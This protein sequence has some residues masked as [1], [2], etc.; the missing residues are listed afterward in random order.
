MAKRGRARSRA[1]NRAG[2]GGNQLLTRS[3]LDRR[4]WAVP[5]TNSLLFA[6]GTGASPMG[7]IAPTV[8]LVKWAL[9]RLATATWLW[10]FSIS[11]FDGSV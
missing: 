7:W 5:I 1:S 6:A 11:W 4:A 8:V 9:P 3:D 2:A 10:F